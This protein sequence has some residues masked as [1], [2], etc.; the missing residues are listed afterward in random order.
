MVRRSFV[1]LGINDGHGAGAALVKDR[2][3]IAALQEER[4]RNMKRTQQAIW[5]LENSGLDTLTIGSY[6]ITK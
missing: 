1:V 4:P 6:V 3:V 2:K 5:T